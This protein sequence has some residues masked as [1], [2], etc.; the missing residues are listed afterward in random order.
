M[1]AA[2]I[3][4][5]PAL[6]APS[7]H[8][9]L[10][11]VMWSALLPALLLI[12]APARAQGCPAPM[13]RTTPLS[14]ELPLHR[15]VTPRDSVAPFS[16]CGTD[17]A[18]WM[19]AEARLVVRSGV[20]DGRGS[21]GAPHTIGS[22]LH[23]RVGFEL[24]LGAVQLRV[25]P[26]LI[27][28][29]NSDYLTFPGRD[30]GRSSFASPFYTGRVSADLP[31]RPGL[32]A[33]S[34]IDPGES[35]LWLLRPT[36]AISVTSALPDWGPG[37]GEGLV[38][39]R[40]TAGFPRMELATWRPLADGLLRV[41]WFGGVA[42]ESRFFDGIPRNDRRS[43]AGLRLSYERP[44]WTLGLSRTVMEGRSGA[45]LRAALKPLQ[46]ASHDTVIEML[47][48]D[49]RFANDAAGSLAWIEGVRQ[50]P[51]RSFRDFTLMPTEGLAFR[52][53][54]SQR[55]ATTDRARWILGAEAVRLDQPPQRSG[56]QPQDLYTSP[57]VVQGW[58]H[59]GQPLGSGLGPGGQRQLISLD[60]EGRTWSLGGFV[61]RM[62]WND[63]AMYREFL[64]YQNRHDVS[65]QLGLRA[66]R[67]LPRGQ[68]L[69]LVFS[70][71]QRLNYLFQNDAFL[72]GYR[73]D[74]VRFAQFSLSYRP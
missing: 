31:S 23:L 18:R 69:D 44:Q 46:R 17:A 20:P 52:V 73:T 54:V 67:R 37:V 66:G 32:A 16:A 65:V 45:E 24:L 28:A 27:A 64:A 59:R 3:R 34:R 30:L 43:V 15:S 19:P 21:G 26:E 53:G 71:G 41:R 8:R 74:D 35:G 5:M 68:Q 42:V 55:L 51:L 4:R 22:T 33:L 56:R 25:A 57:Y 58:T 50:L 11:V 6:S 2:M 36:Y 49:L 1:P 14:A 60:R 47:A 38:L 61:E 12:A 40:S 39:G 10:R 48:A 9:A 70:A 13:P 63:D 29:G 7:L 62:R 72:A